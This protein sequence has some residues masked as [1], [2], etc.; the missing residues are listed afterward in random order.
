[1]L[2]HLPEEYQVYMYYNVG[3]NP[4]Y[5]GYSVSSTGGKISVMCE[6][7][8]PPYG[9]VLTLQNSEPPD[10]KLTNITYFS[11]FQYDTE[12]EVD[13]NLNPLPTWLSDVPGDYR[14]KE[15]IQNAILQSKLRKGRR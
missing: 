15:E 11:D 1:M 8:Y 4:R 12:W 5:L 13:I 3:G 14:K 2:N 6:I 9:F 7:T 10:E